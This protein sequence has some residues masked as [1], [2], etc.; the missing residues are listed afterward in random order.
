MR[1]GSYIL[2]CALALALLGC[3]DDTKAGK[4]V[5]GAWK[6]EKSQ[7]LTGKPVT[8]IITEKS[9]TIDGQG[10]EVKLSEENGVILIK[11]VGSDN[12]ALRAVPQENGKVRFYN[13]VFDRIFV[14][15]SEAEIK[16][17]LSQQ[18]KSTPAPF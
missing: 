8:V 7:S 2:V 16:E 13:V 11:V 9:L 3:Q 15:S 1:K 5:I 17:I 4:A 6:S 18:V 12:V 14:P 10:A